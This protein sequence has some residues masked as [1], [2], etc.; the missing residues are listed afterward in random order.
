MSNFSLARSAFRSGGQERGG[1]GD[2]HQWDRVLRDVFFS[3]GAMGLQEAFFLFFE[4][5]MR[6][7]VGPVGS[8]SPV[9]DIKGLGMMERGQWWH[10]KKEGG[11][12]GIQGSRRG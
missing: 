4:P 7:Q 10:N 1:A 5:T 8:E 12:K 11:V 6:T 9:G 2:D 3:F